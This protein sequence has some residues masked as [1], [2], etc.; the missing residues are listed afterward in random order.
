MRACVCVFKLFVITWADRAPNF[1]NFDEWADR[2]PN[3]RNFF[4]DVSFKST[5][6]F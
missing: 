1:R 3:F 6:T 5:Y 4:D 2:A